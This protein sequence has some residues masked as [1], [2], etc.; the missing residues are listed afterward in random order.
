MFASGYAV[1]TWVAL[2]MHG[3]WWPGRQL[4][5]VLPVAVV[6]VAMLADRLA[7]LMWATLGGCLMGIFSWLWLVVEASTGRRTIIV[8]FEQT[9]NPV[10]QAWSV[11]L[12]DHRHFN[13]GAV[14][15]TVV[16]TVALVALGVWAWFRWRPAPAVPSWTERSVD[17]S[18][19]DRETPAADATPTVRPDPDAAT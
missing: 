3:W 18:G 5:V 7:L 10:Y 6:A 12:P 11:L 13:G 2:T 15:L 14:A 19:R 4:V 9:A 17:A 16:W 1:A 8:D